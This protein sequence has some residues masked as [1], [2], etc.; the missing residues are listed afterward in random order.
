MMHPNP[1]VKVS[2][3]L[4]T[5][6]HKEFIV[7]ALESI[8]MQEVDFNY[9]IIIGDDCSSDFTQE[10]LK[11]YK[12]KYPEIIQLILHP[13]RYDEI[14]GRT[15]NM[16]NL[17]ACRGE[18]IAMLD[19]DDYWISKYKLQTQVDFLDKNQDY[20]LSFHDALFISK[21]IGFKRYLHSENREFLDEDNTFEHEDIAKK[22]F[23]PTSTLLYRNN[24]KEEFPEWFRKVYTADYALQLLVTQHGK[25]KYFKALLSSRR[26]ITDSFTSF[27]NHSE[28]YIPLR[29][30]ELKIY[31]ENF[32]AVK[33]SN[34][35]NM[36]SYVFF[37]HS[38][39]LQKKKSFAKMLKY[40]L[41]A[42]SA[43]KKYLKVYFKLIGKNLLK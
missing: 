34:S 21:E 11:E 27:S 29:V 18:Y 13:R 43:D 9:E 32:K 17:Y 6:N 40:C 25:I 33:N 5:Y 15:N 2:I 31:R 37:R 20:V 39:Y 16:T 28:N 4:I 3:S 41:K 38:I 1:P 10:I 22:S 14:P 8:L 36:L 30:N 42:I 19:G 12:Q 24:F 23:M 26:I 7:E 35:N